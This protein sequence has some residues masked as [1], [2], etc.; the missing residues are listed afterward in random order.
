MWERADVVVDAWSRKGGVKPRRNLDSYGRRC[1]DFDYGGGA[2]DEVFYSSLNETV[3]RH[4]VHVSSILDKDG[5]YIEVLEMDV[6][7]VRNTSRYENF[8]VVGILT[9]R[10]VS[11][12]TK[13]VIIRVF[14]V[15]SLEVLYG[16]RGRSP[17]L[18]A[19]IRERFSVGDHVTMKVSPWK[20]VVRFDK[21]GELAPRYGYSLK[22]R[23]I[24]KNGHKRAEWKAVE[25]QSQIEPKSNPPKPS[26]QSQKS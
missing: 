1:K 4:G 10:E 15:F 14:E 8:V 16:R 11:F 26:Q 9:F 12:S 23:K 13:I 21:K 24:S 2:Y 18:Q 17:V 7:V 3:A 19:E 22:G 20:G 5:M 6:E 25:K